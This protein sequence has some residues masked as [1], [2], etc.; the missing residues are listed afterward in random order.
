MIINNLELFKFLIKYPKVKLGVNKFVINLNFIKYNKIYLDY[1]IPINHI[2]KLII[3]VTFCNI[4]NKSIDDLAI[5]IIFLCFGDY[6]NQSVNNLPNSIIKI[7]FGLFFNQPVNNLPTS[8]IK[9]I[10]KFHFNQS[11]NYLPNSVIYIESYQ[12]LNFYNLPNH[13]HV[14]FMY[15][16]LCRR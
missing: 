12:Y 2:P 1:Y 16:I 15:N 5:N 13:V 7:E 3:D 6:F 9:L 14:K 4:F 11:L 10:F 8:I